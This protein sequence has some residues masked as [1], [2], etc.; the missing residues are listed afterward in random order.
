MPISGTAIA[1]AINALKLYSRRVDQAAGRIASAGL[2]AVSNPSSSETDEPVPPVG[3]SA[4]SEPV[5]LGDAMVDMLIAQRA[6]AAQLRVL[7]TVDQM[8]E[9]TVRLRED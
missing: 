8:L 9:E 7:R 3:A 6:F 5:D 2:F 1:S 4:P